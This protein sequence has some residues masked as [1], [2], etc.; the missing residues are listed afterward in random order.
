MPNDDLAYSPTVPLMFLR[1]S[2]PVTATNMANRTTD[3][4]PQKLLD[5][6]FTEFTVIWSASFFPSQDVQV[7]F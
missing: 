3:G 7:C 5:F 2:A 6:L 1:L 4:A